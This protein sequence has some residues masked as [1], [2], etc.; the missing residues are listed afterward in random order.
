LK[1]HNLRNE[2]TISIITLYLIYTVLSD[3]ILTTSYYN[4]VELGR[5]VIISTH[6]HYFIGADP[7]GGASHISYPLARLHYRHVSASSL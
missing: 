5:F 3:N 7:W 4:N 1:H 6:Y 2:S